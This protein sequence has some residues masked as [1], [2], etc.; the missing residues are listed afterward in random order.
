MSLILVVAESPWIGSSI[1]VICPI[2]SEVMGVIDREAPLSMTIGIS[3]L[4]LQKPEGLYV[5]E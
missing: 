1:G 2:K 4:L 5:M 3:L